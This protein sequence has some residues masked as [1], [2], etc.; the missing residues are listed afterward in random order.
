MLHKL[1]I[2]PLLAALSNQSGEERSWVFL[3]VSDA[4]EAVKLYEPPVKARKYAPA[5]D[6]EDAAAPERLCV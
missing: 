5:E 4:V 1:E 6:G 2:T 3:T